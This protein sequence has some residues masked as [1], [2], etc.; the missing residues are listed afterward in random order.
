VVDKIQ[1]IDN[2]TGS[3]STVRHAYHEGH[4]DTYARKFRGFAYI[5]LCLISLVQ[6][7]I[8]ANGKIKTITR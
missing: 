6:C 1:V 3:K 5:E 2:L 7:L 4:Y 8:I